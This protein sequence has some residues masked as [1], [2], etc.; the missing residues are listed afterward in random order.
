MV[1]TI[2]LLVATLVFI[3]ERGRVSSHRI[4]T[5]GIGDKIVRVAEGIQLVG[6]GGE[7]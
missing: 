6:L 1:Q 5:I 7:G 2:G 4:S 3:I